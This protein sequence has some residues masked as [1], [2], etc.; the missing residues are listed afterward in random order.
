MWG[1]Y[2]DT[3]KGQLNWATEELLDEQGYIENAATEFSPEEREAI[4]AAIA[5]WFRF[6]G[7]DEL[8]LSRRLWETGGVSDTYAGVYVDEAQDLCE[9]QWMLL[10]RM[11]RHPRGLF[12]AGDPYQALRPSGFHW[13]RL[14]LRL[15]R[16]LHVKVVATVPPP[17]FLGSACPALP[18][19]SCP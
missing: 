13:N 11:V 1:E 12:F 14:R 2:W 7:E 9:V 10:A 18:P 17:G 16:H 19:C 6:E 3:L 4:W 5:S 8:D 15:G